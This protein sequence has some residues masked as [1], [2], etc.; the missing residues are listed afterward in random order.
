MF[1][2]GEMIHLMSFLDV[3]CYKSQFNE[4]NTHVNL[5]LHAEALAT[6]AEIKTI[7]P[8]TGLW[9]KFTLADVVDCSHCITHQICCLSPQEPSKKTRGRPR[10]WRWEHFPPLR[11]CCTHR[12][13]L[14]SCPISFQT[15]EIFFTDVSEAASEEG[16]TG[17]SIFLM[18]K[19][20]DNLVFIFMFRY[21]ND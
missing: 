6:T 19:H 1:L 12:S 5:F 17:R 2:N 4:S 8:S 11:P 7:P 13:G 14:R 20:G 21:C 16:L 15:A 18:L 9:F 10:F 3:H